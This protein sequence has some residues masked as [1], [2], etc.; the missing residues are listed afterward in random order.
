MPKKKTQPGYAICGQCAEAIDLKALNLAIAADR[1]YIH[2]CG[3]VLNW[4]GNAEVPTQVNPRSDPR[5]SEFWDNTS[6]SDE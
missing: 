2:Y 4:G 5:Y 3:R 6:E 1:P